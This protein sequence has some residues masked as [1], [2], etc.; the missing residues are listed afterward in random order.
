MFVRFNGIRVAVHLVSTGQIKRFDD[1]IK[2]STIV[3]FSRITVSIPEGESYGN[4]FVSG[5][6]G[7]D[8]YSLNADDLQ[9]LADQLLEMRS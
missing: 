9:I 6:Q 7:E 3:H 5:P 1:G 2:T 8:I 4:V